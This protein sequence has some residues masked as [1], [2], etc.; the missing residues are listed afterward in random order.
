M[1]TNQNNLK[2]R[3]LVSLSPI[4][5]VLA[6]NFGTI[7]SITESDKKNLVNYI[8]LAIECHYNLDQMSEKEIDD[9]LEYISVKITLKYLLIFPNDN[10]REIKVKFTKFFDKNTSDETKKALLE[11]KKLADLI[12]RNATSL[13]NNR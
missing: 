9:F 3:I 8:L 12:P 2:K 7:A 10:L 13:V 6:E 1:I 5:K 11:S 4:T